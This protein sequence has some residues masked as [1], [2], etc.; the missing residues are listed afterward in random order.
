MIA[1]EECSG[2]VVDWS[3][4]DDD[5]DEENDQVDYSTK[6]T[7]YRISTR[8]HEDGECHTTTLRLRPLPPIDGVCSPVG[9]DAW[10]A[11]ALM[12]SL[13]LVDKDADNPIFRHPFSK[14]F[15]SKPNDGTTKGCNTI[16]ELGSGSVGLSGFVCAMA[17]HDYL[18]HKIC[19]VTFR[20]RA[21]KVLMTDNDVPVL[22]QLERNLKANQSV[23][24]GASSS[25]KLATGVQVEVAFWDWKDDQPSHGLNPEED[26]VHLVVGSEL[27]YTKETGDAC[28]KLLLL[29]LRQYPDVE[30]WIVQVSDRYGWWEVVVPT[31][32]QNEICVDTIPIAPEIHDM[33][34][35]LVAM[36]GAL[37]R[38]A[39]EAFCIHT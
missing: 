5:D 39:Y 12:A 33:A 37:D 4:N 8:I 23:L 9:A 13:F 10:Y 11:S 36:G 32:H 25:S 19:D 16:L 21:W 14:I 22:E 31:L 27:V 26:N 2:P 24:R 3:E 1:M 29:L 17:L 38:H 28:V 34:M 30:I 15:S 18:R 20:D 6:A 7:S 35:G